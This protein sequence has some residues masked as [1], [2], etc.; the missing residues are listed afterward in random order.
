MTDNAVCYITE[1]NDCYFFILL[2]DGGFIS[3]VLISCLYTE[4][5]PGFAETGVYMSASTMYSNIYPMMSLL[6]NSY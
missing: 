4:S 1:S 2:I 3:G 5:N 6:N